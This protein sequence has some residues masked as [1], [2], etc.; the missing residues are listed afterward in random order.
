MGFFSETVPGD[1][2]LREIHKWYSPNINKDMEV[3]AY[4]YYGFALLFFP[5][6]TAAFLGKINPKHV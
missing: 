5:N 4:G 3:A 6:T 2:L 1:Y